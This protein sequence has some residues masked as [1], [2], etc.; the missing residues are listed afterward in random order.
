MHRH[1][2]G[3]PYR[4]QGRPLHSKAG[5]KSL[6]PALILS[7][8]QAERCGGSLGLNGDRPIEPHPTSNDEI[9]RS[10]DLGEVRGTVC[11]GVMEVID[12]PLAPYLR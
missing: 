12:Y 2:N 11:L 5:K 3:S 1:Q 9:Y 10:P 4:K 7:L 8:L 6:F